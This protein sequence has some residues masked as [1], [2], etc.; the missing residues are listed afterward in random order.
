MLYFYQIIIPKLSNTTFMEYVIDKDG[1][2]KH[3]E[4]H[5]VRNKTSRFTQFRF[6]LFPKVRTLEKTQTLIEF[7]PFH[8]QRFCLSKTLFSVYCTL[9][10]NTCNWQCQTINRAGW[11][12]LL[13]IFDVCKWQY[14]GFTSISKLIFVSFWQLC[15]LNN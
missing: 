2:R 14:S 12:N 7:C 11:Y 9:S 1:S 13:C 6:I 10:I 8:K 5:V 4:Y 15:F 3:L